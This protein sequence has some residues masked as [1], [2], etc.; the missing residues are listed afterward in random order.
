M[1][2]KSPV[3]GPRDDN[4]LLRLV[5]AN[6][7]AWLVSGQGE[8]FRATLMPVRP[9]QVDSGRIIQVAGH[10][11]RRSDQVR[12]LT[13]NPDA[14]LLFLGPHAYVSSAWMR[15]RKQA[16]TWNFVAARLS[17]RVHFDDSVQSLREVLEDLVGSMEQARKNQ[18]NLR[19]LEER[20]ATLSAKIVPWFGDVQ[21][22][23]ERY[24]LGQDEDDQTFADILDGLEAGGESALAEWMRAFGS[25]R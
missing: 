18:W 24:K 5:E 16:P 14:N 10:L 25:T 4:D 1:N 13:E 7:M 17:I 8:S 22:V 12:H 6:P 9:W 3:F 11:P 21:S 2:E 20:Y 23:N 19:E 15:N